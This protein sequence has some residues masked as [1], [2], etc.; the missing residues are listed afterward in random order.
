LFRC[1]NDINSCQ[2]LASGSGGGSTSIRGGGRQL[3]VIENPNDYQVMDSTETALTQAE[4]LQIFY[5]ATGGPNWSN[6]TNWG[7]SASDSVICNDWYGVTCNDNDNITK[8]QL[9]KCIKIMG[10]GSVLWLRI[11]IFVLTP[12]FIYVGYRW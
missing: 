7:T 11:M 6:N 3:R 10:T 5:N 1:D 9:G 2:E 4:I 12:L 8:F